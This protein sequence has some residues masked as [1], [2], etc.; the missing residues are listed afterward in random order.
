MRETILS[1]TPSAYE[2]GLALE[3][4]LVELFRKMGYDV[5]HNTKKVGRS[6]AEHQIDV[7]AQYRCPLH[8]SQVIV[9]A[10]SYDLPIDKDRIMKLIQIVDDLGADHGIIVTTSYFTPEAIKTAKG[11]NVELWNR[12]QLLKFLGEIQLIAVEKGLPT[13]VSLKERVAQ[14]IITI[15]DAERIEKNILEQRAKGG[16]LGKGKI[17]EK[18]NSIILQYFPYYEAEIQA[19]V[20]EIEKTGW[21]S[22][23]TVQK[24]VTVRISFD[25]L[26]GDIIIVDES[27]VSSPYAFL[28]VLNEDE[29]R[30]FRAM[31]ERI[32][33][34][35]Q[36][37][38]GL[39]FSEGKSKKILSGLVTKNALETSRGE[40][41]IT[42]Y[43]PKT[44]F[45]HDPRLLRSIS[46]V[47]KMQEISKFDAE[48]IPA[49]I[50]ASDII[51]R[52]E[53]YWN[54]K[55]NKITVLYYPYYVCN[56][57]TQDGSQRIDTIDAVSGKLKEL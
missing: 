38:V 13:E 26:N 46:D 49:K 23:R 3:L 48:F 27:G 20:S 34:N 6:G 47:L 40:R 14:P 15:Q 54:A 4:K 17:I 32:E 44:L 29:I 16:F 36:S 37:V 35:L 51:K 39:G 45:P 2:K 11:H 52:I 53:F 41:G 28:K 56:L 5:I 24:L 19:T 31:K 22:T 55:V 25:A 9:E 12:E 42:I 18:F 33:Y 1:E 7:L 10:K 50:E 21:L 43:R 8:T 57:T 30:V